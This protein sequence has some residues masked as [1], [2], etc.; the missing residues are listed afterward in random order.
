MRRYTIDFDGVKYNAVQMNG[1][2]VDIDGDIIIAEDS[3]NVTINEILNGCR[4]PEC[5][6]RYMNACSLDDSICGYAPIRLLADGTDKEME[7]Y[8]RELYT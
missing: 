6:Q 5:L 4:K 3:L 7:E 8:V 2:C 1:S